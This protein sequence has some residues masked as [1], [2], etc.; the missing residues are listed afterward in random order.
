MMM[1]GL[2]P[3]TPDF[4]ESLA[5]TKR[6]CFRSSEFSP[7]Y[8]T[9]P[10]LS[11]AYQSKVSSTARPCSDTVSR[12][13]VHVMPRIR[14]CLR[15]TTESS[16]CGVLPRTPSMWKPVPG[17]SGKYGLSIRL[18]KFFRLIEGA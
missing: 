13:I 18:T 8:Q 6:P 1:P 10:S 5:L 4:H 3:F 17:F 11:C 16:V 12:T 2:A 7:M 9:L 14:L 15:S